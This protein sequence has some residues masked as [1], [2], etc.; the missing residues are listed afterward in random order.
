MGPTYVTT[1]GSQAP[2][3]PYSIWELAHYQH[4]SYSLGPLQE[5]TEKENRCAS[6]GSFFASYY[7]ATST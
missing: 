2:G 3:C 1:Q 7:I 6:E 4:S 5:G